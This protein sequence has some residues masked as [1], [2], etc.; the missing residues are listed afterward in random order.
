MKQIFASEKKQNIYEFLL[1]ER[2]QYNQVRLTYSDLS[3]TGNCSS[4]H[5]LR[6]VKQLQSEGYVSIISSVSG[7]STLLEVWTPEEKKH[8]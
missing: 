3:A 2:D 8:A 4:V 7:A 1:K 5:A 6:I